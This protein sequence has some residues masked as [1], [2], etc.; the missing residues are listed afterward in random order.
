M[1]VEIYWCHFA[2]VFQ[3]PIRRLLAGLF[4]FSFRSTKPR[5]LTDR[6]DLWIFSL[7]QICTKILLIEIIISRHILLSRLQKV[8]GAMLGWGWLLLGVF[9]LRAIFLLEIL[10]RY[11]L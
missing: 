8:S 3:R 5:M 2:V 9:I 7:L 4:L 11:W 6:P 1:V 10:F